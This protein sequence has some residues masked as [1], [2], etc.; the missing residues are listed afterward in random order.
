MGYIV[1]LMA[2]V[3]LTYSDPA[4]TDNNGAKNAA[5][6]NKATNVTIVTTTPAAN[7]NQSQ[8]AKPT[9]NS[10]DKSKPTTNSTDKSKPTTEKSGS[11]G[12]FNG[13]SVTMATVAT[14]LVRYIVA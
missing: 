14:L 12:V 3:A 5:G 4:A 2:V 13:S 8:N 1:V 10:T 6:D 7:T 11:N 9:T